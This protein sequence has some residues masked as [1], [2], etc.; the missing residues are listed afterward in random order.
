MNNSIYADANTKVICKKYGI[1]GN[2]RFAFKCFFL[3]EPVITF[4]V[5]FISTILILAYILRI[6]EL[7]FLKARSE[8]GATSYDNAIW[9]MIMTITTVGYGDITP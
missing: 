7:P 4:M 3:R 2:L 1:T 6:F 9:L 5:I 8:S